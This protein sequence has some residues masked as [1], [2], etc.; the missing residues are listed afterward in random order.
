ANATFD[1]IKKIG[2]PEGRIP[3][4]EC[5]IYL[6][7]SAKSN[8]AYMAIDRA[9]QLVETTGNMPVPLHLR[10]A[11]TKLMKDMGYK[12][13]YKYAHDYPGNFVRQEFMPAELNHPTLWTPCQNPSEDKMKA[14]QNLR[15]GHN[16]EP[17]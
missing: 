1:V 5:A 2:W 13:G 14:L 11:P 16:N 8:S 9:L 15:W 6:A 4:A 7:T 17:Q 12:A 10:N 3:L